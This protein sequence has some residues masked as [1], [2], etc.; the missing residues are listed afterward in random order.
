MNRSARSLSTPE[1]ALQ[2]AVLAAL[3]GLAGEAWQPLPGGRVNFLW[4]VG[5]VVV[6]RYNPDGAS[7]LFP[8]DQGAEVQALRRFHPFGLAPEPLA[9]A[10]GWLAYRYVPGGLAQAAPQHIARALMRLHGLA[11]AGLPF[12]RLASGSHA[13]L[14]QAQAIA[15]LCSQALP[16][17]P[18]TGTVPPVAACVIHGDAVPGNILTTDQGVVLIDWQCPALGDPCEDIAAWLSPAMQWLYAGKALAGAEAA[19]FLAAFPPETVARYRALAP[20]FHWR[21][22]AHCLWKS[23]QGAPDYRR[24]LTLELAALAQA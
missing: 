16:P 21:M 12:R 13:L 19:A 3:P 6:K 20:L 5:K 8:N 15:A 18:Q 7:P 23:R 10:P 22:A 9:D 1:P 14:G 2:S 17:A 11:A 24:A 4:R